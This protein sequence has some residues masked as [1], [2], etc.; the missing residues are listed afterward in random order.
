MK[1]ARRVHEAQKNKTSQID[2]LEPLHGVTRSSQACLSGCG[3]NGMSTSFTHK[4]THSRL[5]L[6]RV[7]VRLSLGWYV[8]FL[9]FCFIFFL[10]LV[11]VIAQVYGRA[12]A[13]E[14][15]REGTAR[16]RI[17][18]H[19]QEGFRL[20]AGLCSLNSVPRGLETCVVPYSRY[21]SIFK[22]V[23]FFIC[24][25]FHPCVKAAEGAVK[26]LFQRRSA[27]LGLLGKHIDSETGTWTET[28]SGIG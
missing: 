8:R 3:T 25:A 11:P 28:N 9:L 23:E 17:K 27:S 18:T 5:L 1:W 10:C 6:V 16:R 4:W 19:P 14:G 7:G 24:T 13:A 20:P 26:A 2:S 22:R 12:H 21:F 15:P